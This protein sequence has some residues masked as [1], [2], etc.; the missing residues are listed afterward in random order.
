MMEMIVS[1]FTK[2]VI[3]SLVQLATNEIANVLWVKNEISKLAGK[4]Q[5]M[6]AIISDAEKTV[7][8][9]ET[10]KVWLKKLKEITYEAENIIDHCRIEKERL[11]TSQ[12][13]ECNPSSVFKCC[14]DVGID[15]K[16]AND[17]RELNEKLDGIKLESAMLHLKPFNPMNENQTKLDLDVGPDLDPDIVGREV[18]NDSDSLIELLKREDIPNRHLFAIIGTIGVGKTTLARKVYHKAES[19]FDTRVWVHFSKDLQRL[20]MWSGDGFSKDETAGQQV[21]LRAWLQGNKFLLVIDDVRKNVWDRVLEIQAQHGKPG[22]RVL[23]TARDERVATKMGAVHLHR[24][25]GLNEDD[26]WWLLRA[27]AF[28]DE[29]TGEM[30]DI[31]RRIVQKCCGLPMAIRGIGCHLRNVEPKEDDWERIYSSDFCGI[32]SRIRKAINTSYLELPYY[33]KRCFLYCSLYPEGSVIDRQRITQQWIA[34][35]G[36]IMP[37]QKTAQPTWSS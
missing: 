7:M 27:R 6:E 9:Y 10:T 29:N 36:F 21:Q 2:Q 16:I 13:Q 20:A 14:R 31:G 35:E 19:M 12:L 23:L 30:Q 37:Q 18:E 8:Q 33:M 28:L 34:A 17:I 25:K 26:G 22:S 3:S 4:L 5:S 15:C 32:S 11:Q 1:E 24:V